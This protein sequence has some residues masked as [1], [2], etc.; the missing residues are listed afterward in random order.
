VSEG[1]KIFTLPVSQF[2]GLGSL[3]A[4]S[5]KASVHVYTRATVKKIALVI[6]DFIVRVVFVILIVVLLRGICFLYLIAS[7]SR[8]KIS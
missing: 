7:K 1:L 4:P 8:D 3:F 2:G 6:V 5:R